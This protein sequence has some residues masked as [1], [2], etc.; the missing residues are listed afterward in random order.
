[1]LEVVGIAPGGRRIAPVPGATGVPR[2]ERAADRGGDG[3][4]RSADIEG[5]DSY[6]IIKKAIGKASDE[7]TDAIES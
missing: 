6:D 3:A 4:N 2:I 1:M 5:I 7:V